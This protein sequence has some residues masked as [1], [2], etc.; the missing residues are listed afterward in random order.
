MDIIHPFANLDK[1]VVLPDEVVKAVKAIPL[2]PQVECDAYLK[3]YWKKFNEGMVP[4]GQYTDPGTAQ[5]EKAVERLYHALKGAK[6]TRHR[7]AI[8]LN[9]QSADQVDAIRD[10]LYARNAQIWTGRPGVSVHSTRPVKDVI[11]AQ[12]EKQAAKA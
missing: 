1:T 2:P 4:A 3:P 5:A 10:R 11:K 8:A 6:I 7:V 12:A 9:L